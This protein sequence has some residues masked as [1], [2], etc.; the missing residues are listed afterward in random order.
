MHAENWLKVADHVAWTFDADRVVLADLRTGRRDVLNDSAGRV[1]ELA[2]EALP[3]EQLLDQLADDFRTPRPTLGEEAGGLVRTLIDRGFLEWATGAAPSAGIVADGIGPEMGAGADAG[4]GKIARP[5]AVSEQAWSELLRA[6]VSFVLGQLGL[7]VLHIKGASVAQWLY[8][9]GERPWGDVDIM[10]P[11]SRLDQALE[12]LL[13]AGMTERYPGVNRRTTSDHAITLVS[14][15]RGDWGSMGWEVDVHDRFEG[16]EADPEA[17]FSVLW[18]QRVAISFGHFETWAPALPARSLLIPINAARSPTA[19]ALEDL[20]RLIAAASD[21]DWQETTQL[22]GRLEALPALRA[23][24]ELD[25]LGRRVVKEHLPDVTVSPQ[26]S[27]RV[28]G[29]PRTAVRLAELKPM[30]WNQRLRHLTRWMVPSPAVVRMRD[31][32]A[33]TGRRQLAL[34]YLR[35]FR[36]GVE[37]LPSAVRALRST[38]LADRSQPAAPPKPTGPYLVRIRA[39]ETVFLLRSTDAATYESL[40]E[41]WGRCLASGPPR[42]SDKVID[43]AEFQPFWG[44]RLGQVLASL[45]TTQAIDDLAGR[46]IM[47]HAAGLADESGAVIALVAPSGTGKTTAT[48]AL[49]TQ[50]FGYVTDETVAIGDDLTV[51]AYPKPL[52]VADDPATP[53]VKSQH[54]PDSLGLKPAPAVL[55]LA[56]IVLLNRVHGP[57]V[58]PSLTECALL[59]AVWALMPEIS[60]FTS[61]ATPLQQLCDLVGKCGVWRLTYSEIETAGDLLDGLQQTSVPPVEWEALE[62]YAAPADP[63]GFVRGHYLDAVRIEDQAVVL[64]DFAPVRL[65]PLALTLWRRCGAGATESELVDAAVAEHGPHPGSGDVVRQLLTT[66]AESGVLLH[67]PER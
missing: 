42:D 64:L 58:E 3:W 66:M 17:A 16:I 20:R 18:R 60:A 63:A 48:R 21:A 53:A 34:A 9:T 38:Q 62:P 32:S 4:S 47:L 55:R 28:Q 31:P 25:P 8:Q 14:P 44:D 19:R 29:A 7:P 59:E 51:V 40:R 23:G 22:A 61:L 67:Y 1:W 37:A 56:R 41:E 54:S 39:L 13:S 52:S 46:R 27:L 11:P 65:S 35:R 5:S 24:L 15:R 57:R 45:L 43:L 12:A 2:A 49:T 50:A 33:A 26:W 30:T 6:E 36:D 10:V